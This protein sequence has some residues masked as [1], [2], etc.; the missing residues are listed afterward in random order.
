MLRERVTL[1][2]K[3]LGALENRKQKQHLQQGGSGLIKQVSAL[4]FITPGRAAER[5]R[6]RTNPCQSE[7]ARG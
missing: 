6:T 1:R 5:E 7:K 2:T 4:S 3:V